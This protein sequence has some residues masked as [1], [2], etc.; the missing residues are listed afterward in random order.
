MRL[1]SHLKGGKAKSIKPQL[2]PSIDNEL[3][4]DWDLAWD[5]TTNQGLTFLVFFEC[6]H[7]HHPTCRVLTPLFKEKRAEPMLGDPNLP[8]LPLP[9]ASLCSQCSYL[10]GYLLLIQSTFS[11]GTFTCGSTHALFEE[12]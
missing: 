11:V 8:W 1:E 3:L 10:N 7:A 5:Y 4:A 9:T 2:Y 6:K 12:V